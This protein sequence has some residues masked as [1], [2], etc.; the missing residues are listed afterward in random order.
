MKPITI[1]ILAVVGIVV[2]AAT[3]PIIT[4]EADDSD[5]WD[6]FIVAGQSNTYASIAINASTADPVPE[7][8]TGYYFG[9]A[10][11][12]TYN[13][14]MNL[15]DCAIH[16]LNNNGAAAIGGIYAPFAAEYTQQTGH[17]VYLIDVGL[18]GQ[19]LYTF[20]PDQSNWGHVCDTIAAGI[21]A[22]PTSQAWEC[23]GYIWIQGEGDAAT[24]IASYE[25]MMLTLSDAYSSGA[26]GIRANT[27]YICKVRESV[28]ANASAAQEYLVEHFDKFKMGT[29]LAD[30]FTVSNG[31][32]Y[33]DDLHYSQ[34]GCNVLGADLG[35][36]IGQDNIPDNTS[37]NLIS[38]IPTL[39]VIAVF[40]S[41]VSGVIAI[42]S[43][44]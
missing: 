14:S 30:S 42:R 32:M 28:S 26:M 37:D 4:D 17:K 25:A 40:L 35:E 20:L 22:I 9:T 10:T 29:D 3:I 27:G 23:K 36:N 6:V 41:I 12:P 31:M 18:S 43:R 11:A 33:S 24:P 39:L 2:L 13:T 38:V 8:E 21:E 5:S 1:A 16:D 7:P 34:N 44:A 19:T 15:A